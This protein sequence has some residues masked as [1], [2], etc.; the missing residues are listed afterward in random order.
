MNDPAQEHLERLR[1]DRSLPNPDLSLGFIEQQF[2]QEI[3]KPYKQLG[4]LAELWSSLLPAALAEQSRLLGLSR[5]TLH[6]EVSNAA[7]HYEI[8]RLLRSGLQKKLIQSHKGAALRKVQIKL[9]GRSEAEAVDP[10]RLPPDGDSDPKLDPSR[11]RAR[12]RETQG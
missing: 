11:Q 2:K 1:R 6:V 8:D 4:D 3:A 7:A 10:K 9:I 5:G 12:G